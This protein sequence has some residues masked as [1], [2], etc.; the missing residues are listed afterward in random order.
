MLAEQQKGNVGMDGLRVLVVE[1]S[2]FLGELIH[3][4]LSDAGAVVVGPAPTVAAAQGILDTQPVDL[5]CLDILLGCET[6]FPIADSL[7]TR[8]IAFV[9]VTACDPA[10]VPERHRNQPLIDKMDIASR[11]VTTCCAAA[12]TRAVQAA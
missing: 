11:L 6:S 12:G 2:D 5:V 1:D 10:V 8:K 4:L 3:D 9:F 7:E